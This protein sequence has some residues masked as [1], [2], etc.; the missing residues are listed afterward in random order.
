MKWKKKAS[1]LY[2]N[3]LFAKLLEGNI[4]EEILDVIKENITYFVFDYN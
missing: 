3:A 4:K 1:A 2:F